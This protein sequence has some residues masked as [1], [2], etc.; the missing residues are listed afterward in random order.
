V[1]D[2]IPAASP[3]SKAWTVGYVD[4]YLLGALV[5][6]ELI[7]TW[8]LLSKGLL[9]PAESNSLLALERGDRLLAWPVLVA[10]T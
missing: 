8:T 10:D 2:F 7:H 5:L 4:P 3:V 9:Q 6:Q 1:E